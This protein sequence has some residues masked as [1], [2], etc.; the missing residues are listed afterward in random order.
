MSVWK[1]DDLEYAASLHINLPSGVC[2]EHQVKIAVSETQLKLDVMI[3]WPKLMSYAHKIKDFLNMPG[4]AKCDNVHPKMQGF[5]QHFRSKRSKDS[6]LIYNFL[7]IHLPFPVNKKLH[8]VKRHK[9]KQN[10]HWIDVYL[11]AMAD[12]DYLDGD[13]NDDD[14]F[15]VVFF[16]KSS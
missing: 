9:D 13:E 11:I 15:Q 8:N 16:A 1:N 6:E 5:Y 10:W 3:V 2:N 7:L 4:G 14:G 12:D